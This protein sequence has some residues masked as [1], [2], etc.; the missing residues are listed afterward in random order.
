MTRI[1]EIVLNPSEE[2]SILLEG[3]PDACTVLRDPWIL[4]I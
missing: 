3:E 1:S 2:T 4:N